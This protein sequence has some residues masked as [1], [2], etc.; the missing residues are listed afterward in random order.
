[1]TDIVT[2]VDAPCITRAR[3]KFAEIVTAVENQTHGQIG[4]TDADDNGKACDGSPLVL[5]PLG[6]HG[7]S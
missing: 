6:M 2:N 4:R 1:M 3:K 7:G 5:S